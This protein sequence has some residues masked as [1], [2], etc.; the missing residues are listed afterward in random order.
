MLSSSGPPIRD[1][2]TAITC[3]LPLTTH[4]T[5]I[6]ETTITSTSHSHTFT[7]VCTPHLVPAERHVTLTTTYTTGEGEKKKERHDVWAIVDIHCYSGLT[8]V[9][10]V[11]VD[12]PL[13]LFCQ[14]CTPAKT[15]S[16]R[17]QLH[18]WPYHSIYVCMCMYIGDLGHQQDSYISPFSFPFSLT[19]LT[20]ECS[21]KRHG[22]QTT[23][24]PR[25]HYCCFQIIR[26][27]LTVDN[28]RTLYR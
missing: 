15:A 1:V 6:H 5:Y 19:S 2:T 11:N 16:H 22:F 21:S 18:C 12:L 28:I 8:R 13:S 4:P 3:S 9:S 23:C 17:V 26:Y 7:V 14:P 20:W 25:D 10:D 27:M 24:W